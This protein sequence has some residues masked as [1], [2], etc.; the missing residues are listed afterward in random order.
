MYMMYVMIYMTYMALFTQNT[1]FNHA[2]KNI[3]SPSLLVINEDVTSVKA[4][5]RTS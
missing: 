3:I 4:Q 2:I 5:L 1:I